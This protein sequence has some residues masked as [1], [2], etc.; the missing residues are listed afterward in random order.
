MADP[1]LS[2]PPRHRKNCAASCDSPSAR[3]SLGLRQPDRRDCARDQRSRPCRPSSWRFEGE[4]R[5]CLLGFQRGHQRKQPP[6]PY[7]TFRLGEIAIHFLG[8][9]RPATCR[10]LFSRTARSI[11]RLRATRGGRK[12]TR[13]RAPRG[14]QRLECRDFFLLHSYFGLPVTGSAI[15]VGLISEFQLSAFQSFSFCLVTCHKPLPPLEELCSNGPPSE[16]SRFSLRNCP[17]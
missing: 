8:K 17:G 12:S 13:G 4:A 10:S 14:N 1:V 6:V 3:R 11:H 7:R 2:L 9:Y 5:F 16:I 15:Q